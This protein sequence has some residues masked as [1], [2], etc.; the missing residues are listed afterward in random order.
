MVT[1]GV[2]MMNEAEECQPLGVWS[3]MSIQQRR[4]KMDSQKCGKKIK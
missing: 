1:Q 3:K 4:L 2:E